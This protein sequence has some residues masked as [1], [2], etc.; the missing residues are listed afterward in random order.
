[1]FFLLILKVLNQVRCCALAPQKTYIKSIRSGSLL[2]FST[3]FFSA[4]A[5]QQT[6][7]N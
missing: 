5:Q 2:C 1:M 7:L 3:T 6:C 4:K